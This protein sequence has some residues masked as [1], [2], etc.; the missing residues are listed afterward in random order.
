MKSSSSLVAAY[1]TFS[2]VL[3]VLLARKRSS[4]R[5]SSP[6]TE[7][8]TSRGM[9]LASEP[10]FS[11]CSR[12]IHHPQAGNTRLAEH[13]SRRWSKVSQRVKNNEYSSYS[14]INVYRFVFMS[15]RNMRLTKEIAAQMGIDIAWNAAISLRPLEDGEEDEHRMISNYA[16]W[17]VNAKLPHGIES[18]K[19]HLKEVDNVP[20]LVSLFTDVTKVTTMQMV[21][22]RKITC[23]LG[24]HCYEELTLLFAKIEIFQ[25][26]HDTVIAVGLSHMP[27]NSSL[28]S[29]ADLGVGVDVLTELLRRTRTEE[30]AYNSVLPSEILFVSV[31]SAH[32]CAFRLQGVESI[33][34]MPSLLAQGRA[35]L[36]AAIAASLFLLFGCLSFAFFTF[37]SV[38]SVATTMPLPEIMGAF[39]TLQ[40]ILPLM[41]IPMTMSDPDSQCMQRVP[42]KNDPGVT[43]GKKE[44]TVFFVAAVLK[45]LPPAIFP[46][47]LYLIAFGELMIRSEP[48]ILTSLCPGRFYSGDWPSVIRCDDLREYTGPSRSSAI[49]LA[50]GEF[51]LCIIVVSA[52]FVHRAL[53]LHVEPPWRRNALWISSS[54]IAILI[55][56]LYLGLT[57]ETGSFAALPW[58]FFIM[59]GFMPFL[60]LAW[61]EY[62]KRTE[63]S[64]FE[65]AEKL[66]RLQF[67]TR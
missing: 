46:Q 32:A 48:D 49:S 26:Y 19:R 35:S 17:D 22:R 39:L 59:A 4:G 20:L 67:E 18:V 53:P 43:F 31:I 45:A 21:R 3:S 16:D 40:V 55:V 6:H 5:A 63:R 54:T 36:E 34:Y 51:L 11:G 8:D 41:G 14:S 38:C 47:L 10:N 30:L 2:L 66:R 1:H 50:L 65:R 25:D 42:A 29:T 64:L 24:V 15:P 7:Q 13:S 23:K 56:G 37:F 28:F 61:V 52:G 27:R 62:I 57:L 44:D 58:Y 33:A 60:C 9:A 12:V